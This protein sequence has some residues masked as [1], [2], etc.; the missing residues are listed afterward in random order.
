M[1]NNDWGRNYNW[2][3]DEG[4]V[5][6]HSEDAYDEREIHD[7]IVEL[8][9]EKIGETDHGSVSD[10]LAKL[11]PKKTHYFKVRGYLVVI[12]YVIDKHTKDTDPLTDKSFYST[13]TYKVVGESDG[14]VYGSN[15]TAEDFKKVKIPANMIH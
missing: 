8:V 5:D 6:V 12:H 15:V 4:D 11:E 1:S 3:L 14:I 10:L 2:G 9:K 13:Y 7:E